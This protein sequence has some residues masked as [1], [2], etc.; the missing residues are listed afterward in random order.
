M[1]NYRIKLN[2]LAVGRS[3]VIYAES[4]PASQRQRPRIQSNISIVETVTEIKISMQEY[5]YMYQKVI[6]LWDEVGL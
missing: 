3:L 6:R 4:K 2:L 1:T 5:K